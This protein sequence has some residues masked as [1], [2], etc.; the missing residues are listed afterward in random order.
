MPPIRRCTCGC[1]Q[2]TCLS[3]SCGVAACYQRMRAC[4]AGHNRHGWNRCM[5]M[6]CPR[7]YR[8]YGKCI[9]CAID[10]ADRAVAA[11]A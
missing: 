2:M 7:C 5:A 3:C 11:F 8:C 1:G 9:Y 6:M 10:D 4:H